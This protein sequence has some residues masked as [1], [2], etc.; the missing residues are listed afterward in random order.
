M[1]DYFKAS[2]APG[3]DWK[4]G[5][6]VEHFVLETD[7]LRAVTYCQEEG[8]EDL[9]ESLAAA[10]WSPKGRARHFLGLEGERARV[11]LE[12][13][14]QLELSIFPQES[15]TDVEEV[16]LDCVRQVLSILEERG[17]SLYC[18]GYQPES[19]IAEIPIL[20]KERYDYMADYFRDR[21]KYA[22]NMMKATGAIH[23]SFDYAHREDYVRKNLVANALAPLV[24]AVLDNAPFFEGEV[25][26]GKGLRRRI[27][28]NCDRDRCGHPEGLFYGDFG[29][30]DY[31]KYLLAVPP[32][33]YKEGGE[34]IYS[35][36]KTLEDIL[37]EELEPTEEELEYLLTTVFPDVRTKNHLEVRMADSLPY[38]YSLAYLAF[39]KGLL[40]SR[41][42]LEELYGE[43]K[44]LSADDF[45]ER[46]GRISDRGVEAKWNSGS[47]FSTFRE[48]LRMARRGLGP[49]EQ[50]YLKPLEEL[51]Q[52]GL[53]PREKTLEGLS[54]GKIEGLAWCNLNNAIGSEEK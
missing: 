16:Y 50:G 45:R 34:L 39:W 17:M 5:M 7:S 46:K 9:L 23:V 26:E 21:G 4:L 53:T 37:L 31:A 11:T 22:H 2:R 49:G 29:Y 35:G 38:P 15:L 1:V 19:G 33:V 28:E 20:P 32:M 18:L 54:D 41:E 24:Y 12:P 10:W 47:V 25:Y 36:E 27:W 48:L 13:G 43:Y 44:A 30:R 40:Y 52:A 14:G 8:I 3:R 6:E 51:A 42:N